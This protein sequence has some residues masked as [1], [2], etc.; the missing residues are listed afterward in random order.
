MNVA[1]GKHP[2]GVQLPFISAPNVSKSRDAPPADSA[3]AM[4]MATPSRS[5]WMVG[6]M[7]AA[8]Y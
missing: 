1:A 5:P 2:Q 3:P 4:A 7:A 6:S 8:A